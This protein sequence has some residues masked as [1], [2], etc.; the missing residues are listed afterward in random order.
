M[1]K[2]KDR[3]S[4]GD[5]VLKKI[6]E[7]TLQTG[8]PNLKEVFVTSNGRVFTTEEEALEVSRTL[9]DTRVTNVRRKTKDNKNE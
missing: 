1:A 4:I 5:T 3:V 9:N 6:G 7:D 2:T 8:G